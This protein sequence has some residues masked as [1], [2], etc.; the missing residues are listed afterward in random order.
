VISWVEI[1]RRHPDVQRETWK[2]DRVSELEYMLQGRWWR[3]YSRS[4]SRCR[5][6]RVCVLR[7]SL[8]WL[9]LEY[10][11][12]NISGGRMAMCCSTRPAPISLLM[13]FAYWNSL[14]KDCATIRARAL[15]ASLSSLISLSISC[16]NSIKKSMSLFLRNASV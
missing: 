14:R 1:D 7:R 3:E 16:M 2:R 4:R 12:S 15:T 9:F 13:V 11:F 8:L 6:V 5:C 10:A